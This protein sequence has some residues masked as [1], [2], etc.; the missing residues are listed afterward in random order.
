RVGSNGI[1][2]TPGAREN[3]VVSH[4][5]ITKTRVGFYAATGVQLDDFVA[6]YNHFDSNNNTTNGSNAVFLGNITADGIAITNNAFEHT[7]GQPGVSNAVQV[8]AANAGDITRVNIAGNS[9]HN[10]GSFVFAINVID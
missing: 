3:T 4:N 5:I 7:D 2:I 10:D 8:V 1:F 9:S 6:S